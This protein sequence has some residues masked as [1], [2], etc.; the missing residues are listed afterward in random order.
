M[1]YLEI[2]NKIL[3]RL[4]NAT[5]SSVSENV[6]SALIGELVNEAKEWAED[7]HNWGMLRATIQTVTS[8]GS[9]S[10]ALTGAGNRSMVL[11]VINDTSDFVFPRE[12][13][14]WSELNELL[15]E[16]DTT[17]QE[18]YYWGLNGVDPNNDPVIHYYPRPDGVYNINVNM[19][20]PQDTLALDATK[21][22]IP[23]S[24]VLLYTY[25]LAVEERGEEGGV[26][27]ERIFDRAE[28]ALNRA[29]SIDA[30]NFPEEYTWRVE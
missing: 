4:R 21:L 12:A 19:L 28:A 9:F 3:V 7:S 2:V 26:N 5:V 24:P 22:V 25:A 30:A 1:T 13:H 6:D 23:S 27:S 20:V 15:T 16:N 8:S 14:P 18:P 17:N 11:Q 10:F 29:A